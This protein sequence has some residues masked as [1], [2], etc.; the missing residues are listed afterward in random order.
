M[1]VT[2]Q[3]N[4]LPMQPGD[5]LETWA[6]IDKAKRLLNYNPKINIE[7]GLARF[8]DWFKNYETTL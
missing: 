5:V 1:G 2:A 7:E 8:V 4:Y 6:N 3:K